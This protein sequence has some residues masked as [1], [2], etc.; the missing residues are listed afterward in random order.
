MLELVRLDII[1][2]EFAIDWKISCHQFEE[3]P[4]MASIEIVIIDN[5]SP[6]SAAIFSMIPGRF[7]R[8]VAEAD[9]SIS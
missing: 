8:L 4:E 1:I 2:L 7:G 6:Q 5:Q 9:F 3:L